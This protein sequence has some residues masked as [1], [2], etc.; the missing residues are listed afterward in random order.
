METTKVIKIRKLTKIKNSCGGQG[1][2]VV[3]VMPFGGNKV[4]KFTQYPAKKLAA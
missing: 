2:Q 1:C 3:Y 4:I